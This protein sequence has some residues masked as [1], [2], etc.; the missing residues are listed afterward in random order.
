MDYTDVP[1]STLY[2][3]TINW[4]KNTFKNPDKVIKM[5]IENKSIRIQI[6]DDGS[7]C[8]KHGC[9]KELYTVQFEF[10]KDKIKITPI[11][12]IGTYDNYIID[13]NNGELYYKSNGNIRPF[14]SHVPKGIGKLINDYNISLNNFITS[15]KDEN[16]W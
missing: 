14:F 8:G 15:E 5:T 13:L 2:N 16:E 1:Q 3:K 12:I 10:R 4:V 6:Y 11:E 9:A 7:I